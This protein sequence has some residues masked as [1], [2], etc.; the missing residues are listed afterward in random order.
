M[1]IGFEQ[2]TANLPPAL[3][4]TYAEL[5]AIELRQ[6]CFGKGNEIKNKEISAYL[7]K[8]GHEVREVQ[9]R[10]VIHYLRR[11]YRFVKEG[12]ACVICANSSGYYLTDNKEYIAEYKK[13]I[14][15]RMDSIKEIY[16]SIC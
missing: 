12:N 7:A 2:I 11:N 1:I 16:D 6:S 8:N 5:V 3:I 9:I 14:K 4:K 13:S 10:E 15:Q